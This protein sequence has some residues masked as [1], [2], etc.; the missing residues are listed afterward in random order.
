[1]PINCANNVQAEMCPICGFVGP[2]TDDHVFSQFLGGTT[3]TR[4]CSTCNSRFGHSFEGRCTKTL[5]P[6]LI[7]LDNA[8]IKAPPNTV[9]KDAVTLKSE[10]EELKYDLVPGRQGHPSKVTY[11][12]DTDS[13]SWI[14]SVET[15]Q[16]ELKKIKRKRPG[17]TTQFK[18]SSRDYPINSLAY[19]IRLDEDLRRLSLKMLICLVAKFKLTAALISAHARAHLLGTEGPEFVMPISYSDNAANR[20]LQEPGIVLAIDAT[21]ENGVLGAVSWFGFPSIH[22]ILNPEHHG[23]EFGLH[24]ILDA[25]TKS[26]S[27]TRGTPLGLRKHPRSGPAI[28]YGHDQIQAMRRMDRL[29]SQYGGDNV[30][31]LTPPMIIQKL[32]Q[33]NPLR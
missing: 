7:F 28:L 3:T 2:L 22:A 29:L 17:L 26:E 33:S 27:F 8:G 25:A 14:G 23:E 5:A 6:F 32:I 10:A 20:L 19:P 18:S 16:A 31:T 9:W 1:M 13:E 30:P 15:M 4:T 11:R 24:A 12:K 21:A